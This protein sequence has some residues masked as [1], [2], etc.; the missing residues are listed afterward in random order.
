MVYFPLLL[1]IGNFY[2]RAAVLIFLILI[3]FLELADVIR[4]RTVHEHIALIVSLSATAGIFLFLNNRW[5]RT[6]AVTSSQKRASTDDAPEKEALSISDEGAFSYYLDSFKPEE[7]CRELLTV[8]KNTIFAD[9]VH[10][11]TG[12]DTSLK[13][14]CSTEESEKII[15]SHSGIIHVCFR[16]KSSFVAADIQEKKIEA[17]YLKKER[18][19]SLIVVSVLDG[20][21]PLGVLV[22]DSSRY[23]AFSAAD[24][25]I[26]DMFS[27]QIAK[28]LQR[29][30]LYPSI[31]RLVNNMKLLHE[32]SARLLS[33]LNTDVI[34]QNLIDGAQKVAPAGIVFFTIKGKDITIAQES[35]LNLDGEKIQNTRGTFLEM[36]LKNKE[37]MYFSDVQNYRSPMPF[38]TKNIGSIFLLPLLYEQELLGILVLLMNMRDALSPQQRELLEVLCNQASASLANAKFH[39]EIERLAISDG[40][41]GLFN[42]RHFQERLTQEMRRLERLPGSLSVLIIDIDYFKRV[43]DT[44]GHPVGDAVLQGVADIITATIREIDI[45]A[46]YGGEEFAVILPGTEARGAMKMAE[47]LRKTVMEE[48]YSGEGD[49]FR[50]TV[51]IGVAAYPDGISSKEELIDRADKALYHA[52]RSGRNQC[53]LWHEQIGQ[54]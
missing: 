35:G 27:L 18:I 42:H 15:P 47:R 22:A 51:S 39:A 16:G 37:K 13:L 7:E 1:F 21:Y 44:Y 9:S 10:L 6:D 33:S 29:E 23:Q 8:A 19:S 45:A 31:R 49:T 43:N 30:R 38:K 11:F 52:K 12:A 50:V 14:K 48:K 4:N 24:K 26:L 40:L 2:T 3:P 54:T 25:D 53:M 28:I 17:G 32:G 20:E 41:T 36:A 34:V 46:R 5:H